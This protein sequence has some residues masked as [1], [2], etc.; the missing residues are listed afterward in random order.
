MDSLKESYAKLIAGS[1]AAK[2]FLW[3]SSAPTESTSH[4]TSTAAD[5]IITEAIQARASDIHIEPMKV[6]LRVRFR[7]D[8][9]LYDVLEIPNPSEI[10]ITARIKVLSNLPTDAMSSKK[11]MDGRFSFKSGSREF[12]FR[13]STF[14]T[15][16]GEKIA[17]RILNKDTSVTDLKKVGFAPDDL[18]RLERCIQRKSGLILVSGPTGSGKTSTLYAI[19]NRLHT[20]DVNIVTLEDPVEYQIEGI[21]QVDIRKSG[22]ESFV[23]GLKAI[24]RQDPNVI[25]IGEIRDSETADIAIRA[26]ITGHLVLSSIHANSAIGTVIRLINM[27][28]ERFMTCY[29]TIGAVAQRLV[30]CLCT[31][32]RVP[33][34]VDPDAFKKILQQVGLT[35]ADV[36]HTV[37]HASISGIQ[38]QPTAS[39]TQKNLVFYKAAGCSLCNN[40]GYLGR[41][42]VFEVVA[43][44]ETLRNAIMSNASTAEL[45]SIAAQ[46]G[47]RSLAMD[48]IDKMK[49]GLITFEDV[50]PILLENNN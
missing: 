35:P 6:G 9:K 42:G 20:S 14:P 7:I 34:N 16:L 39:E 47:C 4:L 45:K 28:L 8:G 33:Y 43:F 44:N 27:G 29:A 2:L 26:S 22:G 24:L 19:L 5:L 40:T 10:T 3:K 48:A 23:S 50:F 32:C 12:D 37:P 46:M 17:I 11:S 18:A 38:L 1:K 15:I 41:V 36:G 49:A 31:Q 25:L 13:V 30:P 21:N